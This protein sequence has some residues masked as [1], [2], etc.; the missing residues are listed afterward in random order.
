MTTRSDPDLAH[1]LI[2]HAARKAPAALA[3]RL[4]EEWLADLQS[5]SGSIARL[6]LALGCCWATVVI[7]RE[8]GV[9]QLAASGSAASHRPVVADLRFDLPLLSRRTLSFLLIAGLHVL[10]IYAFATGFVQHVKAV[11]PVP[12]HGEVIVETR[13]QPPPPPPLK[14]SVSLT[15][16]RIPALVFTPPQDIDLSNVHDDSDLRHATP[17][18]PPGQDALPRPTVNRVP[19]GPGPGFPNTD[20]Y[21]PDTSRRLAETGAA[22][23]QVCVDP[24]GRLSGEPVL[25]ESSGSRRIDAAAL[26]LA[27]AGSGHYRPT[28]ENG[29]PVSSCYA[30]RIRFRLNN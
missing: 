7:T 13:P 9:P 16:V 11:L 17:T 22:N 29:A 10:L 5:R 28:T 18:E 6:R 3:E 4:E 8:L 23:V 26:K 30:Y 19:G 2:R 12:T 15:P 20:D 27:R 24:Q 14:T 1:R 25:A 21:Y